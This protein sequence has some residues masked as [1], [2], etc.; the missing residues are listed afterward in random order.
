MFVVILNGYINT[1]LLTWLCLQLKCYFWR[2][3]KLFAH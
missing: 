2:I 3:R 1:L